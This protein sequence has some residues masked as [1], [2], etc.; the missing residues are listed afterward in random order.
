M[1]G[2]PRGVQAGDVIVDTVEAGMLFSMIMMTCGHSRDVRTL[3]A[4]FSIV[5]AAII[6][7]VK[8]GCFVFGVES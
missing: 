3:G 6:L 7:T 2:R 1:E 5:F 8:I 4:M